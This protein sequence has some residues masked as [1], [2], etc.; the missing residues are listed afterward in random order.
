MTRS[1][2]PSPQVIKVLQALSADPARWRYGYD[3][4]SEV[5]L[6]SGSLYPI[7]IRLADRALLETSWE[8]GPPR[9]AAPA[10]VSTPDPDGAGVRCVSRPRPGRTIRTAPTIG[11][12]RGV[13]PSVLAVV[14]VAA[15][16]AVLWRRG[17]TPQDTQTVRGDVPLRLVRWAVGVL[18][19]DRVD[20]GQAMLGELDRIEGRSGRWRFALGCVAGVRLVPCHAG[21]FGPMA[22]LAAVA[23][24]SAACFGFGFVHFGLGANPWN[25]VC[26]W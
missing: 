12:E 17:H 24:G 14:L 1:R 8:P 16:G 9:P 6:K 7:L 20:W 26:C 2:R 21:P 25:W 5:H 3:L 10:P 18:P 4:A 19:A 11:L 23:L 15:A 22:A 13:V